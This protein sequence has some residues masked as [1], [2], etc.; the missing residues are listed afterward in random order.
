MTDNQKPLYGKYRGTVA[1]NKDPLG[2][3]RVE[4]KVPLV[5]H[6]GQAHWAMP[7]VPFAGQGVGL[8]AVPPNGAH[9]W[10]EFEGGDLDYPI[11]SGCFWPQ[12]HAP[13]QPAVPETKIL[14][15]ANITLE[16][17]DKTGVTLEVR[18]PAAASVMKLT[19]GQ[20]G[21]ELS[22]GASKI[23]LSATAVTVNNGA[24]EIT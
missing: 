16:L 23:Q 22:F 15:T 21:I 9:V 14:K 7:C 8:F 13:A 18:P 19:M 20:S 24:L 10:V 17:N 3:G 1:N 2:M 6:G 12:G 4:V 5:Y 11:W